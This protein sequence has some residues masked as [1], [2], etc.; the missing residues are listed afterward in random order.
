[1]VLSTG[2]AFVLAANFDSPDY[3]SIYGSNSDIIELNKRIEANK[4]K[5]DNLKKATAEYA[6]KIEEYKGKAATLKNQL[7]LL[8]NQILKIQL[9]IKTSQLQIDKTKLEID[10]LNYQTEKEQTE[11]DLQKENL[12]EYIKQIDKADQKSYLEILI[13][14]NSFSEFF[15]Q[16][17]YLEGVQADIKNTIDRLKFLKSSLDTQKADL[18]RQKQELENFQS[19]LQEQEDKLQ[20]D[21]QAKENLVYE[22]RSSELQFQNLLTQA[23]QQQDAINSDIY[24]LQE[25]IKDKINRIKKEG[26]TAQNTFIYWPVGGTHV[27][28]A[29]FHDPDYPFRYI[30]E[31]PAIDIRAKQGSPVI[32][33]A[34]G[35]VARA[36]DSG[37]GYSYIILIHDNGLSTVYGHVSAIYVKNDDFVKAGDVIGLSGAMPGT[38]GAGPF[39]TGPHLH[40]EVRLN[41]I[42]VNPLEYL[43]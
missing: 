13:L 22:T 24:N 11:I 16:I 10:A 31:H 14:N 38:R 27:I 39:T 32:A 25:K 8:D 36:Q 1:M 23:K 37:Y 40:F 12:M 18:E 6:Q 29:Y 17:S 9:D 41:G 21:Q 5:I 30:F 7:G 33:P 20:N 3:N 43:P 15:N 34:D 2:F 35:Y 19:Q 4:D 28:T 42:P 26:T